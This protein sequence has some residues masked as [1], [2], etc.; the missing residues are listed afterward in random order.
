MQSTDILL[1]HINFV[2]IPH[3]YSLSLSHTHTHTDAD[4]VVRFL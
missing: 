2:D 1:V 4:K 3:F